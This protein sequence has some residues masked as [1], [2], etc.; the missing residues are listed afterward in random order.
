MYALASYTGKSLGPMLIGKYPSE[1]PRDGAHFTQYEP[2]N[3]FLAE[4]LKD[5]GF[6]TSGC[7]SFWYFKSKYGLPQG[8]DDWDM[9]AI[10]YD[11]KAETDT[12]VTSDKLT[13]VAIKVLSKPEN[14]GGRFFFW[15][16][17]FDPHAQYMPHAGSPNFWM[18][19]APEINASAQASYDGE[20]WFTDKHV[21]RL[22]DF[23]ASQPWGND[24]VIVVTADHG[25]AFGEHGVNWHGTDLWEVLVRVP[26][27]IYV[28]GVDPHHVPVKRSHIDIVPTM[29]DLMRLP[30]PPP[31]ELSGVSMVDDLFPK[32]AD[33][34]DERDVLMD[35]PPGP[36]VLQ[37]RAFIHGKSPG[38]KLFHLGGTIY[39][40]YDLGKDPEE[41]ND[42]TYDRVR[43]R[44][45]IE[46]YQRKKASL[47]E[48]WVP[49]D[50]A[51]VRQ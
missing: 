18:N 24:T 23:I 49:P 12:S 39:Q 33:V 2:S 22:L 7:A 41:G 16:H 11:Y 4:R 10:P 31:G 40:A 8:I 17:Y 14:T 15:A 48:I 28:P 32:E 37:R 26:M 30:Q 34:Y 44:P 36:I 47:R 50:T 3:V 21:G 13:D 27:I 29:L 19:R 25:E 45:L 5:A 42:F 35:M 51:E 6:N 1:A 20:V 9:S 43:S 46:A 38:Q